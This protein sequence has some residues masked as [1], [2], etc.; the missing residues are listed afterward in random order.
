[1]S[2]LN[3][4]LLNLQEIL[5]L[6]ASFPINIV[7]STNLCL[8]TFIFV[9]AFLGFYKCFQIM[10]AR[11]SSLTFE[12]YLK[13]VARKWLRLAPMYYIMW[14]IIWSI[15]S[16]IS[17]GPIWWKSDKLSYKCDENWVSTLFM[18]GNLFPAD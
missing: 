15:S 9:S 3:T 13:I 1:M 11:G 4:Q 14:I 18:V 16:R 8:E 10:E 12:D 6:L 5:T 17:S 7:I 2:I